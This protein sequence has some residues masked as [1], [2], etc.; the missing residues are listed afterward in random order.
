MSASP[1]TVVAALKDRYI[2]Q[3]GQGPN[4]SQEE[5]IGFLREVHGESVPNHSL[6]E[7][8]T[9]TNPNWQ[10]GSDDKAVLISIDDCNKMVFRL[11]DLE[12]EIEQ[13]LFSLVPELA[14]QLLLNPAMPVRL[15]RFSILNVLD[16]IVGSTVGWSNN[17]G[18]AGEQLIKKIDEII[19]TIRSGDGDYEEL[20]KDL[21][22]YL[23]KEHNRIQKLEER[24]VASEAGLLRSRLSK[25][26]AAQM[27]NEK[28]QGKHLT[29]AIIDFLQGPWFDS[30]QLLLLTKGFDGEERIRAEK[31][32][33]TIVWTYQPIKGEDEAS[34]QSETQRLYRIIEHLPG[35]IRQLLV[36][37]EHTSDI[38]ESAIESIENEHVQIMSG[39]ELE[40]CESKPIEVDEEVFNQTTSVSRILL[41]KVDNLQPGQ[42]FTFEE[43]D[44]CIRIK[45]VLKLTDVKQLLFTN[46]NGMKALQKS[47]DEMAYFLSSGI[48]KTLNAEDVFSSAYANYYGIVN[49][50][51]ERAQRAAQAQEDAEQLEVANEAAKE[52][53]IAEA[54]A[55]AA[56][57]EE[58]EQ[59]RQEEEKEA[60]L[61]RARTEAN[62]EENVQRV[63]ELTLVVHSLNVSA[64]LKL[65]SAD[66]VLE[67]CKLAVKLAAADKMI[68]VSR[69]GVKIGE[70]TTDQL[71]QLLVAGEAEI[72]EAG[73]EFEDTLAQVVSK[74]R[75]DRNKSYDDLTG[76]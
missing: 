24:L 8:I 2:K 11:S 20:E 52:K 76:S 51:E 60:R 71:V 30:V 26:L 19:A 37:L 62:K 28:M 39:L 12:P 54:R 29:R 74:L 17:L 13:R 56:A 61:E 21:Q 32:T 27:V 53:A 47:F 43:D 58:A 64:W 36:A 34:I 4:T 75:V 15:P 67:E 6:G 41:R 31:L 65:P 16:L 25:N 45:L 44:V 68:F 72:Q 57:K 42:W 33:E 10:L 40:L 48:V 70:Y 50:F 23:D 9:T 59:I 66:G 7:L 63:K 69:T 46:R 55:I 73:V 49:T 22:A 14:C 35:E 18:R 3:E 38:A 1:K 5:L